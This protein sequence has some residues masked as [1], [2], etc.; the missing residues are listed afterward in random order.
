MMVVKISWRNVWRN[1]LR[2]SVVISSIAVGIWA[3]VFVLGLSTGLNNQRQQSAINNTLSH[4]QIHNPDFIKDFNVQH[5][6]P[7]G[8]A[9]HQTLADD[10]LIKV[11]AERVIL[12]GMIS[13]ANGVYGVRISGV[14]IETEKQVTT[15]HQKLLEGEYLTGIKRNPVLISQRM[16]KKLNVKMRSKVVLTF[17]K[18]DGEIVAAA[19]RVSGIYKTI[20]SRE[21]ELNIYVKGSDIQRLLDIENECHEIAILLNDFEKVDTETKVLKAKFPDLEI[22]PWNVVS[23]ELGYA[24]EMMSQL[25]YL[26]IAIILFALSFGIINTM[27]MAVLERNRELAMFMSIGMNRLLVFLMIVC[28]TVF[29]SMIGGPLGVLLGYLTINYYG[30]EG[31]DLSIVSEGLEN[32]GVGSI[33]YTELES[34]FYIHVTIMVLISALLSSIYPAWKAL[35]VNP[36]EG[37]RGI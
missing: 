7:D 36:A 4:I 20:S 1:G 5:R 12:T 11:F 29:I 23:P 24:N 35:K 32:F 37:I 9:V 15:L 18:D 26:F 19:F 2:S 25:L 14:D 31:I 13:S 34:V 16:A 17:Q 28:E 10:P 21:D 27:L 3:G 33:V 30:V 6:I 8:E 22:R